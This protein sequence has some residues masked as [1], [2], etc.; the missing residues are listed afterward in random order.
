VLLGAREGTMDWFSGM[1]VFPAIILGLA[2]SRTLTGLAYLVGNRSRVTW[3]WPPVAWGLF[4]IITS[5]SYWWNLLAGW[6]YLENYTIYEFFYMLASPMTLF[7]MASLLFQSLP[8]SGQIDLWDHFDRVR[9]WFFTLAGIHVVL[10]VV[11]SYLL[12][13][14][15]GTSFLSQQPVGQLIIT[16]GSAA[17][18]GVGAFL[19]NRTFHRLLFPIV[20]ILFVVLYRF[21]V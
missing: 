5:A 17:L 7:F 3:S 8:P 11:D 1:A 6:G 13:R 4:F 21:F 15:T 20:V 18:V 2:V 19:R 12:A 10:Y 14:K 9:P 16:L